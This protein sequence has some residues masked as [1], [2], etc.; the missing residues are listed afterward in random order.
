MQ[1]GISIAL[2]PI[3]TESICMLV[4]PIASPSRSSKNST[5]VLFG[6]QVQMQTV[7]KSEY[8]ANARDVSEYMFC[9][10]LFSQTRRRAAHQYI[11][12]KE[13]GRKP[14]VIQ[15]R[16]CITPLQRKT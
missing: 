11:K 2:Y 4:R 8:A 3:L 10:L 1:V 12:K 13:R 6:W 5:R 7:M 14:Q 9:L 16:A 15:K